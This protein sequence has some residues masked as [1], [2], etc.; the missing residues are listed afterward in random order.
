L[1]LLQLL[2]DGK[3]ACPPD[4][5][6]PYT[7]SLASFWCLLQHP[8]LRESLSLMLLDTP[9]STSTNR[10]S[11]HPLSF[12]EAS[13]NLRVRS[14]FVEAFA[15]VV[16]RGLFAS[17]WYKEGLTSGYLKQLVELHTGKLRRQVQ[18]GLLM[19]LVGPH[20]NGGVEGL[21]VARHIRDCLRCDRPGAEAMFFSAVATPP[22][23]TEVEAVMQSLLVHGEA[24]AVKDIQKQL[25]A[26]HHLHAEVIKKSIAP[27]LIHGY[28]GRQCHRLDS[29]LPREWAPQDPRYLLCATPDPALAR[30]ALKDIKLGEISVTERKDIESRAEWI[31]EMAEVGW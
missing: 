17:S 9:K 11:F 15:H 12:L 5:D 25:L 27:L 2:H 7:T 16:G 8:R 19:L 21:C 14:V 31:A 10:I 4:L 24:P 30:S 29:R 18:H 20:L 28:L 26:V 6:I 22:K 23:A 13:F 1:A 3:A